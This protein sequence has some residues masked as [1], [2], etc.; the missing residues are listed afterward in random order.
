MLL[1]FVLNYVQY[2]NK[3]LK[4]R[5]LVFFVRIVIQKV[6]CQIR[7]I[8]KAKWLIHFCPEKRLSEAK[9]L[10]LTKIIHNNI[11]ILD[12]T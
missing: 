11:P 12:Y 9:V 2:K 4:K 7:C 6:K 3:Q 1:S 10:K 5:L 8:F